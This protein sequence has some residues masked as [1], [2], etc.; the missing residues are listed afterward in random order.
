MTGEGRVFLSEG[1]R[2]WPATYRLHVHPDGRVSGSVTFA[3]GR[4]DGARSP[5]DPESPSVLQLGTGSWALVYLDEA[6][7][8]GRIFQFGT[9]SRMMPAPPAWA[10]P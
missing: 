6:D 7:I 4:F 5:A 2:S 1:D 10:E 8:D 9:R 3:A